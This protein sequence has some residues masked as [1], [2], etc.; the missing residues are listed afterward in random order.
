MSAQPLVLV[1]EPTAHVRRLTLN[2]PDKRN[3]LSNRLRAE[4]FE[5]LHAGDADLDVHVMIVRGAGSCF[6]AGYDLRPDP[7]DPEPWFTTG[8][9]GHWPRH[10]VTGW[11]DIWDLSTPVIAQVHGWCLAGGSELATACDLVYVADDAQIGYPP[12]RT[13]TTP[14]MQFHPWMMGMRDAMEQMLTGDALSGV[15][16]AAAGWANRSFPADELEAKVLEKAERVAAIPPDLQQLNKR[17][18]HRAMEVMGIRT[19]IRYGS[20]ILA[21]GLHQRSSREYLAGMYSGALGDA[22]AERDKPFGD[23]GQRND[24][25]S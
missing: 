24:E 5:A 18:V 1:D 6:S 4:L 3:A 21:L 22:L 9:D 2:R 23:Y 16:A 20:E 10:V 8:G 14:D 11:F 25:G 13:M 15:E 7:T 12:V 19:A 17:A